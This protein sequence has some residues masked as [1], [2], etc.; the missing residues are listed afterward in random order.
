MKVLTRFYSSVNYFILMNWIVSF[1]TWKLLF[2]KKDLI[3][4][5]NVFLLTIMSLVILLKKDFVHFLWYDTYSFLCFLYNLS[6]SIKGFYKNVYHNLKS[7]IWGMSKLLINIEWI[8][9]TKNFEEACLSTT[10]KNVSD[11][12]TY[13]LLWFCELSKTLDLSWSSEKRDH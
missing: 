6:F 12:I 10:F 5:Q 11:R 9:F 2:M 8:I 4:F 1:C 7:G 13:I 3:N